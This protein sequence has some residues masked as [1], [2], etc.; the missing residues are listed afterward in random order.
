MGA[1]NPTRAGCSGRTTTRRSR[2]RAATRRG[3]APSMGVIT[4]SKCVKLCS[5]SGNGARASSRSRAVVLRIG[6]GRIAISNSGRH[7]SP[8]QM[9][10]AGRCT[11]NTSRRD[12]PPASPRP[13]PARG[14]RL[15]LRRGQLRFAAFDARTAIRGDRAIGAARF[16]ARTQR[17]AEIHD[18]LRVGRQRRHAA[19][20][21]RPVARVFPVWRC[22][23]ARRRPRSAAPV[24][25]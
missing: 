20:C 16:A 4:R 7:H 23:R 9:P 13:P 10:L 11:S 15:R 3:S 12:A 24:R 18:G 1:G 2:S 21:L 22:H 8:P 5:M 6:F 25:V 19:C 17:G 14:A